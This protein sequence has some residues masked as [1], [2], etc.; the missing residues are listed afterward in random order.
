MTLYVIVCQKLNLHPFFSDL[1]YNVPYIYINRQY[2][3]YKVGWY[4]PLNDVMKLNDVNGQGLF[5][6]LN[7]LRFC[8]KHLMILAFCTTLHSISITS[9]Y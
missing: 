4:Y 1:Y 7:S 8:D 5:K 9:I 3:R 6:K 2:Y